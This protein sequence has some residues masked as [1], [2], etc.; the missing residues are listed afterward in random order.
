MEFERS[1]IEELLSI[2]PALLQIVKAFVLGTKACRITTDRIRRKRIQKNG[3]TTGTV[4]ELKV[5]FV[6]TD[7]RH[8]TQEIP[9]TLYLFFSLILINKRY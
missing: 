1:G 7:M 3:S 5:F 2:I 6:A 9:T 8:R 4:S